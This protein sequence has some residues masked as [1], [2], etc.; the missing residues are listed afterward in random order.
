MCKYCEIEEMSFDVDN[1]FNKE[2]TAMKAFLDW[3]SWNPSIIMETTVYAGVFGSINI[4][5][6]FEVNYC[7]FCGRKLED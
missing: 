4:K 5:S 2:S 6:N 1:S 7:P 3:N